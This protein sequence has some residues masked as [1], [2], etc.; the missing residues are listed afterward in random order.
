MYWCVKRDKFTVTCKLCN[1]GINLAEI[2]FGSLKQHSEKNVHIGFSVQL[3][4]VCA[5]KQMGSVIKLTTQGTETVTG[6]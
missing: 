6:K 1:K 5:V 4:E 3:V 2:G